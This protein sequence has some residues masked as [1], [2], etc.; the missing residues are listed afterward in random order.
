MN[1]FNRWT[2]ARGLMLGL[3]LA[4][5]GPVVA[6]AQ[7]GPGY[8]FRQP[9]ISLEFETGYGF[10]R[11]SSDVFDFVIAEHT[12]GRRDFD[13]PYLGGELGI[14]A[15]EQVD[16]AIGFGH[17]SSSIGSEF[18]EWVDQD[19]LPITQ[20]TELS[21]TPFTVGLKY[22]LVP[23]GR[24]LGRFA[25][26]PRRV[27][28]FVGASGGLVSYSFKQYGDFIDFDTDEIFTDTFESDDRTFLGRAS[29]GVNLSIGDQF[30][31]SFEGRYSWA[32]SNM[33]GDFIGFDPIDLSGMQFLGG[34]A[35][36][37]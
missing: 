35:V 17:Q 25:W 5:L 15:S 18:R 21:Q 7:G 32:R 10:Q 2:A 29:A 1:G 30:Y 27:V 31:V 9:R 6:S 24:T 19:G 20:V 22:Y 14:R 23:R 8:L 26:V 37:F 4:L 3:S 16:V 13:S 34:I 28:P 11:A 36:R 33:V 12:I